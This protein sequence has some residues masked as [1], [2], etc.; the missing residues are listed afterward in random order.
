MDKSSY[1]YAGVVILLFFGYTAYDKHDTN[2]HEEKMA[3]MRI[4]SLRTAG[5]IP[6]V[7]TVK[8]FGTPQKTK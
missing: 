3:Q 5:V 6:P 8:V 7:D 1:I 4:D 2:L